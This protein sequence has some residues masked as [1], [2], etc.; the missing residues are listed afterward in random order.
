[1]PVLILTCFRTGQMPQG[2]V[3]RLLGVSVMRLTLYTF[4]PVAYPDII[5]TELWICA[6]K[7]HGEDELEPDEAVQTTQRCS[8][9][10]SSSLPS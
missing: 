3:V 9:V 10:T 6:R 8:D 7:H 5:N 2:V 4:L 1:M